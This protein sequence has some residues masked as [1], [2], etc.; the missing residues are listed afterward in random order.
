MLSKNLVPRVVRMAVLSTILG[1]AGCAGVTTVV[2]DVSSFARSSAEVKAGSFRFERLPSQEQDAQQT[3]ALEGMAQ[4]A[5]EQAGFKRSDAGPAQF[6]VQV[7]AWTSEALEIWP[8]PGLGRWGWASRFDRLRPW[9]LRPALYGPRSDRQVFL[10]KVKLD[11]RDLASAKVVY[12]TTAT[13]E[14]NWF[15][16]EEVLPALFEAALAGFPTP[17]PKVHAVAVVLPKK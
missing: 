11:I 12:E 5:L 6:S 8:E 4:R 2:G 15:V 13:N 7:G 17:N 9:G 1:L 3:A 14:Q 10:T 16:A